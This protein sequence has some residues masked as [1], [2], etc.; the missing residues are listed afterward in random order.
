L[1]SHLSGPLPSPVGSCDT[2]KARWGTLPIKAC[3]TW[4]CIGWGLHSL[5]CRQQSG[6]LLPHLS[7]LTLVFLKTLK[8][9]YFC[10]TIP[11][12]AS[13]K[14]YLAPLPHDARTFLMANFKN[15]PRDC[16]AY[17]RND[18]ILFRFRASVNNFFGCN[19]DIKFFFS[20]VFHQWLFYHR[21]FQC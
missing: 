11:G 15:I 12:V 10:C 2:T 20:D 21:S 16:P 19:F 17:S 6:A 9:V 3:F 8:A 5:C 18:Y 7:I 1:D 14:C 13:A 4:S